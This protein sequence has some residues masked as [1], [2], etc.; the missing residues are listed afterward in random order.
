MT[1]LPKTI[2]DAAAAQLYTR[3]CSCAAKAS[4]VLQIYKSIHMQREELWPIVLAGTYHVAMRQCANDA[5]ELC[6]L[7]IIEK[8]Q[9]SILH[10]ERDVSTV[11]H[12]LLSPKSSQH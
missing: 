5:N 10:R 11:K 6:G 9:T 3:L 4:S 1:L 2:K 12:E 7:R 8:L